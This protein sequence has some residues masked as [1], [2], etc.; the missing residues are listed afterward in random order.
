M[1]ICNDC[2][3]LDELDSLITP[4]SYGPCES[5]HKTTVCYDIPHSSINSKKINE[6]KNVLNEVCDCKHTQACKICAKS[7][8]IDWSIIEPQ[9]EV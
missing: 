3:P 8:G 9:T 1:F 7:K 4:K 5:C 6:D 2:Y